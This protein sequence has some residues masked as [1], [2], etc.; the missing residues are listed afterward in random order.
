M[1]HVKK[2]FKILIVC[3]F[4]FQNTSFVLESFSFQD[5]IKIHLKQS[6]LFLKLNNSNNFLKH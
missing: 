4:I 5:L 6:N 2:F 3:G 1:Y